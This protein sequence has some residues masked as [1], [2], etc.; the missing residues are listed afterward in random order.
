M[1]SV[2]LALLL[3]SIACSI[4]FTVE[5]VNYEWVFWLD[6]AFYFGGISC[7]ILDATLGLIK[8]K[9]KIKEIEE[10]RVTAKADATRR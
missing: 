3:L 7:L 1:A 6:V 5:I 9:K 4:F 2:G 8:N 10:A